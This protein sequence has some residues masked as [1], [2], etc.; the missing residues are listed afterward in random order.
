[1][2]RYFYGLM[3]KGLCPPQ[4][5]EKLLPQRGRKRSNP[6]GVYFFAANAMALECK[7]TSHFLTALNFSL[8]SSSVSFSP[9]H[10]PSP[11]LYFPSSL[12]DPQWPSPTQSLEQ[13][14]WE[15]KA[16]KHTHAHRRT[17]TPVEQI[18]ASG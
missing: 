5:N 1:M 16:V 3:L 8:S 10:P 11:P 9:T 7:P 12:S 18:H 13:C 4:R 14:E 2:L 15:T 17:Q 6:E